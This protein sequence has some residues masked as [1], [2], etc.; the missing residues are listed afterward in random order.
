MASELDELK[1]ACY[2]NK[3]LTRVTELLLFKGEDG[4]EKFFCSEGVAFFVV[5]E[6]MS[7]CNGC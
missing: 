7:W 5:L 4:E 1:H 6:F 3:C 2:A